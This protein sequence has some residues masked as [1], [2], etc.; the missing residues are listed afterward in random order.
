MLIGLWVITFPD[1]TSSAAQRSEGRYGRRCR[2]AALGCRATLVTP[3]RSDQRLDLGL[4]VNAQHHRRV[5]WVQIQPDDIADLVDNCGS[6][7]NLKSSIRC[8]FNPN[9]RQIRDIAVW[10]KPTLAA[11]DRVDHCV[12]PSSGV[13]SNVATITRSTI[14]SVILRG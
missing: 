4:F 1:A 9:V 8:G 11:I 2:S 13:V 10:F 5:G 12:D 14:S 7:D 6:V 3:A